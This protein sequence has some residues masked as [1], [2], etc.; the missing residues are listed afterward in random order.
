M[1]Q[2]T[3]SQNA[4]TQVTE[5]FF[6]G[7]G[8]AGAALAQLSKVC[9]IDRDDVASLRKSAMSGITALQSWDGIAEPTGATL[10]SVSSDLQQ[11]VTYS[12]YSLT[13]RLASMDL[14]D[15]PNLLSESARKLGFAVSNTVVSQGWGQVSKAW[16]H[17]AA[18]GKPPIDDA[19]PVGWVSGSSTATFDNKETTTLDAAGLANAIARLRQFRDLDNVQYDAALGELALIVPP[20]LE[21]TAMELVLP[22]FSGTD[23]SANFFAGYSISVCVNV[24]A[25]DANNWALLPVNDTP[26]HLWLREAPVISTYYQDESSSTNLK[27]TMATAA[28]FR[29]P[30]F[31]TI[32]GN[33]PA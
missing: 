30:G 14:R 2:S 13:V 25:S 9:K 31:Q 19:Q 10:A 11:V 4:S 22:G 26:I 27:A 33:T 21:K 6:E 20:A 28:Y 8:D 29:P 17:D 24:N 5:A 32:V 23:L 3:L 16:T 18:T 7:V 12:Q 15:I 1:A